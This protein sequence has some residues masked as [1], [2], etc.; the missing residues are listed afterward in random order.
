[1]QLNISSTTKINAAITTI[2]EDHKSRTQHFKGEMVRHQKTMKHELIEVRKYIEE[3]Q[4]SLP[5]GN[6]HRCR[7]TKSYCRKLLRKQKMKTKQTNT[8]KLK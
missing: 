3:K 8:T 7:P 2:K 4:T 5:K 6:R 1:M